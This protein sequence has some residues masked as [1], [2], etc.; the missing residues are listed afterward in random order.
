MKRSK[1]NRWLA[2]LRSGKFEQL[3]GSLMS[4]DKKRACCL[5]VYMHRLKTLKR[6]TLHRDYIINFYVKSPTRVLCEHNAFAL[7]QAVVNE[8]GFYG[9]L[10]EFKLPDGESTSIALPGYE[11]DF[12]S[13][14]EMNDRK[15]PFHVIADVIEANT[16]LIFKSIEEDV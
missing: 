14:A 12:Y 16:N 5:G 3:K 6:E 8:D 15:V 7:L 11:R 4:A 13:L 1:L 9:K 2:D 10:G